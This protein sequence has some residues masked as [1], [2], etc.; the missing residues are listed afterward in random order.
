MIDSKTDFFVKWVQFDLFAPSILHELN[1]IMK[2]HVSFL[3]FVLPLLLLGQDCDCSSNFQWLKQTFEEND[4]GVS[5]VLDIKG[6]QAYQKHNEVFEA[7][8]K[9]IEV[10]TQCLETLYEWM[11]FFRSGHI[12]I[13]PTQA[14]DTGSD[15][16]EPSKK[17]IIAQFED[18]ENMELDLKEFKSYL[19]AKETPGYE[20]I[21]VNGPYEIAIKK[22][23]EEY[24]GTIL[25]A[26][27]VYWREG[28]VKLRIHPDQSAVYYMRD[29]SAENFDKAEL[30]GENRLEMGFVD[31]KRTF[32]EFDEQPELERYIRTMEAEKPFFERIDEETA[33]LR[34][35]TFRGSEKNTI[36][37]LIEA[38]KE[39]ILQTPNLI[40][41]IRNN[42]GGADRS[43][44]ELLPFLYTNPI[45]TVGVEYFSTE[46]NNQ[47]MIDFI[48]DPAYGFSD[49]EK[50][51]AKD[52]YEKLS[53]QLGE[54]VNLNPEMVSISKF[55]TVHA[56]PQRVGIIINEGNGS[57][58]EQFLL[59]A[60]QSKKVKLYGTTTTGVLDIS[61]MYFVPSP[62]GDFE[63]GYS[64]SRSMR[65]PG[66]TIDDKGIQPD[67]FL[68]RGISSFQWIEFVV[69]SL[70][71]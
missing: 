45:R 24:V 16:P 28:Q 51:W 41:D 25:K 33:L 46:L 64:L 61:N 27:G 21:W 42:G 22:V 63:L 32:P 71:E 57:T 44:Q 10:S 59:A 70:K 53:Q 38:N 14:M 67:Y 37:K 40:I 2:L 12:A 23:K 4:A 62:C 68:D 18:W 39:S 36:D 54:F 65:I 66:M 3:F 55:D 19:S 43:Y 56:Y 17:E 47:R 52:S 9:D 35:P 48:E 15:G 29:H 26:D 1:L 7:R 34:I 30:V 20:G 69:Q 6:Q 11:L 50:E 8:V 49:S 31:L 13:R 60:K 58:A 5:Y